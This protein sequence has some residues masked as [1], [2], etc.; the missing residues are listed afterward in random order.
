MAEEVAGVPD[1]PPTTAAPVTRAV[2]EVAEE[3]GGVPEV[4]TGGNTQQLPMNVGSRAEA[5]A[6]IAKEVFD[7]VKGSPTDQAATAYWRT[8]N[9]DD[10]IN[11]MGPP[12]NAFPVLPGFRSAPLKEPSRA[13][14]YL[15]D[16][17][18]FIQGID[19]GFFGQALQRA[20]L[21]PTRRTL[22]ASMT[23]GDVKKGQL[24]KILRQH[25]MLGFRAKK[26][27][28]SSGDVLEHI[29]RADV[30]TQP[31]ILL[32]GP[33]IRALLTGVKPIDRTRVVRLAQDTR[34]FFDDVLE[35]QNRARVARGQDLIPHIE[36]YRPWVRDTNIWA[37]LGFSN[38]PVKDIAQTPPMPDFIKPSGPFVPHAQARKGGLGAY[39]KIRDIQKLGMDYADSASKDIFYTNIIQNAKVHIKVMRARGGL[40]NAAE[41]VEEWI[42]EA[43]AGQLP[44]I[45]KWAGKFPTVQKGLFGIR[46]NLSR[47]VFAGNWIWNLFV[48]PSSTTLTIHRYGISDTIRGLSYLIKP[49]VKREVR[50]NAY[51]I[52]I[53][54]RRGGSAAY[55]DLGEGILKTAQFERSAIETAED[56]ANTLTFLIEDALTGVSIRAAYHSGT[57]QGLTGRALWEF[58][59]EGGS[60][61][62]SMYNIHDL[63]GMLRAKEAGTVAPFQTFSFEVMNTVRELNLPLI[64]ATKW[65]PRISGLAPTGMYQT[66]Q[67]RLLMLARWTA[68]IVAFSVV[69]D[70][71]VGRNPW[72]LSSFVPFW[73]VMTGGVNAGN[74]WNMALPLK[75]SADLTAGIAG[76]MKYGNWE[77]LR[78]WA[79]QYHM[80]AGTQINRTLRGI[81]AVAE[82]KVTDVAGDTLFETEPPEGW[83]SRPGM[84][85]A[86]KAITQG[87]Y[88]VAEGKE[89]IEKLQKSP[90]SEFVGIDLD[91]FMASEEEKSRRAVDQYTMEIDGE[92]TT[93]DGLKEHPLVRESI[94]RRLPKLRD[95]VDEYIDASSSDRG[96]LVK[97]P[98]FMAIRDALSDEY[99]Y[100]K[101]PELRDKF[102]KKAPNGW[103]YTA[104]ATGV[105]FPNSKKMRDAINIWI[106]KGNEFPDVDLKTWSGDFDKMYEDIRITMQRY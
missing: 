81:E 80:I 78:R 95:K 6:N 82:G 54:R 48:Q 64:P 92:E 9:F 52:I 91:R 41:A 102:L 105:R 36:N 68:G 22:L 1:G 73:G 85:E 90:I 61:T 40:D 24:H 25:D 86:W 18:R 56:F 74:P 106:E 2:R 29:S 8:G 32:E 97:S 15:A 101:I 13:S 99:D 16:P 5:Q 76:L 89:Y 11:N 46:R 38:Q 77:K 3:V 12:N 94:K 70:K 39:E 19:R 60:K 17:T 27:R 50:D 88:A 34:R 33:A 66:T 71:A 45:T 21:W 67:N 37:R 72:Q 83:M 49:S 10:F 75:Y 20:V 28:E 57:R 63:P 65:T 87:P 14:A 55:Q 96:E 30:E 100:G 47:A 44:G 98:D 84:W 31:S 103:I 35:L 53:K 62:Q 4:G 59:S 79:I 26:L 51:S 93:Y 58:A 104:A 42:M 69:A 23:F 43:F 7:A